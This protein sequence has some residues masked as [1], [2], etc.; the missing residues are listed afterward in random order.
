MNDLVRAMQGAASESEAE[1]W[2]SR[3]E[4][5][6]FRNQVLK[7]GCAEMARAIFEG[8]PSATPAGAFES[9]GVLG[10]VAAG[11]S[12]DSSGEYATIGAVRGVLTENANVAIGRLAD[13]KAEPHDLLVVDVVDALLENAEP[14]LREDLLEALRAFQR[15]GPSEAA[16]VDVIL[17]DYPDPGATR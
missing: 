9:W 2:S 13:M 15:R 5:A 12:R 6:Y 1:P 16:G 17:R 3:L 4:F 8:L 14:A 11:A 10:Q 7:P